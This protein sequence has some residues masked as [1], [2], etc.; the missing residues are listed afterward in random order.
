MSIANLFQSVT[1]LQTLLLLGS[2]R[3]IWKASQSS[4]IEWEKSQDTQQLCGNSCQGSETTQSERCSLL[5][6]AKNTRK[7]G[8][9]LEQHKYDYINKEKTS[10]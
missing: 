3:P 8:L 2:S 4:E 5:Y 10:R 7:K 6:Q 9:F 1:C